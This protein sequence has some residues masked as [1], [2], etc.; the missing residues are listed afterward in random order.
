MNSNGNPT[1]TS[2][3]IK[4]WSKWNFIWFNNKIHKVQVALMMWWKENTN[5]VQSI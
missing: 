4:N 2:K 1:E 3:E 5:T